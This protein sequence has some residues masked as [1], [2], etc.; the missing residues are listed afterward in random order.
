MTQK[1]LELSY[2]LPLV[3]EQMELYHHKTDGVI[4]TSEVAPYTIGTCSKMYPRLNIVL[5]GNLQKKI[6]LIFKFHFMITNFVL[7]SGFKMMNIKILG[8]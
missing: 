4:F 7:V 2:N 5:N 3:F 8:F 6:L 1:R